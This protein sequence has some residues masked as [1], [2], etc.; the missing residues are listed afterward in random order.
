MDD[1]HRTLH[2]LPAAAWEAWRA[3]PPGTRREPDGF[4]EEGFV[5]CTDGAEEMV[6]VA[7]RHYA[8]EPGSYVVLELDLGALD[9]PWRYDDPACLYPHVYGT[10]PLGAVTAVAPMERTVAGRFMRVGRF[11]ST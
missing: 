11:R 10:L 6:V 5:H 9:V 8:A 4:A 3:A 2:L 7:N 1:A